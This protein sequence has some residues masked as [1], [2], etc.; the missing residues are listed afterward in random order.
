M[1]I[2]PPKYPRGDDVRSPLK[3]MKSKSPRSGGAPIEPARQRNELGVYFESFLPIS[4][5]QRR[6]F[7]R[8]VQYTWLV[9]ESAQSRWFLLAETYSMRQMFELVKTGRFADIEVIEMRSGFVKEP[10][11]DR[12]PG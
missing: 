3:N 2:A 9:R 11:Q 8:A 12:S 10:P 6:R 7:V 5:D 4:D 1:A